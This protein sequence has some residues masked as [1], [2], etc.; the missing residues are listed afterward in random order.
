MKNKFILC[1]GYK[2]SNNTDKPLIFFHLPK[3]GGT[4]FS[5]IFSHLLIKPVRIWGSVDGERGTNTS[6]DFFLKNKNKILNFKSQFI[7]GHFPYKI[8]ENFE[9]KNFLKVTILRDPIQRF[10]SHYNMII[11][12]KLIDPK[13]SI[14]S[15]FKENILP[16]NIMTKQFSGDWEENMKINEETYEK[17]IHNLTKKMDYIVDISNSYDL[18]N[19]I[20]SIYNL[21]NIFF[22]NYQISNNFYFKNNKKNLEV[23]RSYNQLDIKLYENIIKKKLFFNFKNNSGQRENNNYLYL[24]PY[25][26]LN[27]KQNAIINK[28]EFFEIY[29]RLKKNKFEIQEY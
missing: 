8:L 13:K 5:A 21:P 22:Q 3:S 17:A 28:N 10:I 1:S 20:V 27:N 16:S 26:L 4:T 18:I 2:T 29:R 7:Y 23:I 19:L 15:C 11:E 14:E 6:Y 9:N 24:S 12:R 25:L